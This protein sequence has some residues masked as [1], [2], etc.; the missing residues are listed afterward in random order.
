M[1]WITA[2]LD[3]VPGM[4]SCKELEDFILDYLDG[5]LSLRQRLS[6]RV[7]LALCRDCR[8]YLAAYK[9]ARQLAKGAS[10]RFADD[11]PPMP[12]ELVEVILRVTDRR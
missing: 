12:E 1:S 6:F 2:T 10:D 11:L 7:H 3:P 4:I 9:R 5:N 8:G